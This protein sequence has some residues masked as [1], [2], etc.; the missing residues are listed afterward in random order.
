MRKAF[1]DVDRDN[2]G[3]I[4]AGD[5]RSFLESTG[6]RPSDAE[7][8]EMIRMADSG[9]DGLIHLSEFF[10]LFKP[11]TPGGHRNEVF[12]RTLEIMSK[13]Q[14]DVRDLRVPAEKQIDQF[15]ASLPGSLNSRPFITREYLRDVIFMWKANRSDSINSQRFVELLKVTRSDLT[16]RV[17]NIFTRNAP[18]ISMK[19]LILM[20]GAFVSA[21]CEE[22]VDFACRILDDTDS[23]FLRE[24][25]VSLIISAHFFAV[26][27]DFKG[28]IDRIMKGS[29]INRLVSRRE[30]T[31]MSRFDPGLFFPINRINFPSD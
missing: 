27:S 21:P 25:D 2:D 18:T 28:R 10:D 30:L 23:G 9:K 3:Q 4:S 20:I 1:R 26:K 31:K 8:N 24:E 12:D 16:D 5:L 7:L 17:F 19:E 15:I 6:E 29:D 11:R 14:V 13:M 22:R